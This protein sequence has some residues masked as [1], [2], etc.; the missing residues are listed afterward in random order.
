MAFEFSH[1]YRTSE[2]TSTHCRWSR[3]WWWTWKWGRRA[4]R[5]RATVTM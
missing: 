2:I 3:D 1:I 5:Y 4:S